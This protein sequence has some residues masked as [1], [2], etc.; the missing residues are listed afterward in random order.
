MLWWGHP[1]TLINKFK[2]FPI[3]KFVVV[4][5]TGCMSNP[6]TAKIKICCYFV[7]AMRCRTEFCCSSQKDFSFTQTGHLKGIVAVTFSHAT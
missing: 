2:L 4:V 7:P 5:G 1:G 3:G 6:D